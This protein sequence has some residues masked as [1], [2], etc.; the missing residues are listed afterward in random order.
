MDWLDDNVHIH[1]E[2]IMGTSTQLKYT[3]S[4]APGVPQPLARE[5]KMS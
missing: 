3:K 1:M 5:P 2:L 4:R